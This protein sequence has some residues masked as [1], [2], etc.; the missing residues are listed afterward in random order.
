ME[1]SSQKAR[2][3]EGGRVRKGDGQPRLGMHK[4]AVRKSATLH[5]LRKNF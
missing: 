3:G 4:N 2:L 1:W 5:A